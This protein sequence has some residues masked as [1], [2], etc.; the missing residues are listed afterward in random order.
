MNQKMKRINSKEFKVILDYLIAN[1][2]IQT[3]I[4]KE[5]LDVMD[6]KAKEMTEKKGEGSI[7]LYPF[8]RTYKKE[9]NNI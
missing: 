6:T 5:K 8:S 9:W 7:K 1:K 4:I 3:K 2:I